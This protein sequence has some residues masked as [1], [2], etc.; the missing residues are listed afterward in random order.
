MKVNMPVTDREVPVG[1][2]AVIL[3][4]TDLKGITTYINQDFM[5]VSGFSADELL[6]KNHNVVRHPD[7]PA[8]A[9]ADLWTTIQTGSPWMGIVKNRCKNGDYYWVDAFATPIVQ[10]GEIFEYQSVRHKAGPECVSRA[11]ATYKQINEEKPITALKKF[12]PL[13]VKLFIGGALSLLPVVLL[14]VLAPSVSV[15]Q[16][17]AA[18]LISLV[19]LFGAI[20]Y[21]LRPLDSVI[22]ES[23][24]YIDNPLMRYIYTGRTDEIGQLHLDR[25]MRKSEL[26]AVVGR[27][28]DALH[29]LS[30]GSSS[31]SSMV[32]MTSQGM[33]KQKDDL[34][35]FATAMHE[36]SATIQDIAKNTTEAATAAEEGR[37]HAVAG[38]SEISDVLDSITKMAEETDHAAGVINKLGES[39]SNI[40]SVLDVIRG[41]AE[42]TNLLALNAAIEAAR[43]GEQGRGF[44]VVA[45]EV[46]TLAVRTQKATEEIQGMVVQLQDESALAVQ[47]MESGRDMAKTSV[48]QG[49]HARDTFT[50]ITDN[51]EQ[52]ED[53]SMVIATAIEEQSKVAEDIDRNLMGISDVTDQTANE[54]MQSALVVEG[55]AEEIAHAERLVKQFQS[56]R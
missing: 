53:M 45:D 20:A 35:T 56:N 34:M 13:K 12:L 33:V 18:T 43:A 17:A 26:D 30:E 47:V 39:S 11:E 55:L 50:T 29:K 40:G 23:R 49:E 10:G 32:S 8:A 16:L 31:T 24:E 46:R 51:V 28:S 27:L 1:T 4:T 22:K 7:M 5:D 38:S 42:Q 6:N 41:I 48:E 37:R 25:K 2:D 3:S 52:I 9:F 14:P 19:I 54:A 36:M 21:V 44:A 15:V